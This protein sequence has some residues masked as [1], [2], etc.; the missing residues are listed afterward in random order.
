[1]PS[2]FY[3]QCDPGANISATPHLEVLLDVLPLLQ[4]LTIHGADARSSSMISSS[5]GWF[6]IHFC[7]YPPQ[8]ILMHYCPDLVETI[9]SPQ[10]ACIHSHSPFDGWSL[11]ARLPNQA[12]LQF[13][14]RDTND[15]VTAP[16]LTENAL[17]FLSRASDLHPRAAIHSVLSA[18]L[19]HQRLGHPGLTQLDAIAKHSTGVPPQL[20]SSAHPFR[21]CQTCS[22]AN[23]KRSPM[24][25][26]VSTCALLPATRFHVDFGFMRASS[27]QYRPIK[28]APR[29]VTSI[30]GFNAYLLIADAKTRY[31]FAFPTVSKAPPDE[32]LDSFLAKHGLTEGSRFLRMDQ[33]GELWR[34][35][36]IRAVAAR[37]GY[38]IE[39]TG[40][41]SANQNG[42]VER[43]N[44]TYGVMV[45]AL[46]YSAGLHPSFWS[47]ALLHAVYLKNRLYHRS[48]HSTPIFAWTGV[49]PDLAH[50]RIFGSLI[51]ARRPGKSPAK[52]DRHTATGIFTGYGSTTRH[53]QYYDLSTKRFK[54]GNHF[55]FD[56]AHFSSSA[57]PP[58]AQLL[59]DLGLD[60][61]PLDP[62]PTVSNPCFA[63]QPPLPKLKAGAPP[64]ACYAPL[65]LLEF[66]SAPVAT[67][68]T[69][70]ADIPVSRYDALSIELCGDSFGPSFD[71]PINIQGSHPTAGLV[72]LYDLDRGRC[73]LT[74][75]QPGTPAN[76]IHTWKSRLR[77][78]YILR[79]DTHAMTSVFDISQAIQAARSSLATHITLT[80]TFDEVVNTLNHAGLPQLYFDQM[81]VIQNHLHK[82]RQP[83]VHK[84]SVS[85]A[86]NLTRRKLRQS[87]AW[88][89]WL[90]AEH[91]QLDNYHAQGMFGTPTVPPPNSAVFYW[92]WVYKIKEMENNRKKARAVCDCSTRGGAAHISGHTFAPTPD[93]VDLRLQVALAAQRGFTLYHAD[94]SNAFAE[95]PRP[96]QMYYMRVDAPFAEW[97]NTRFPTNPLLPGQ[98]IPILKN[99]QGHP[100]APRQW[101]L[102]IHP[103][104]V[105]KVALTPTTHAPYLYSGLVDAEPILFLRQVDDFSI[106]CT[107]VATY[108]R[109]CDLL[110]EE[111][112]VPITRHGLLHHFNGIDVVQARTHIT[113]SVERYL[114]TVLESHGWDN[115]LP[116]SL[117]MRPDND[118]VKALDTAVPLEPDVRT[119]TDQLR[120]R[121]RGAIGELI[122]PMITTRPE[123]AFPVVKLSQFSVALLCYIMM[124]SSLF[125]A[126]AASPNTMALPTLAC[127]LSRH[128]PTLC[129]RTAVLF[130]L[131]LLTLITGPISMTYSLAMLTLTGPWTSVIAVLSRA[132]S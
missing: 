76:R 84:A 42:K 35:A 60:T 20:V 102:H 125:F 22:D 44:G 64:M 103:I 61:V 48:L 75:M 73:R 77:G 53:I 15:T 56:E 7:D 49:L 37:H 127:F 88:P 97:W 74:A 28:D 98:V 118:F 126:I 101:S 29:V 12:F 10:H 86:P 27:S 57:R 32:L 1:M 121:Y 91:V 4:P 54:T 65:P 82:L 90:A 117:P 43:L 67:A 119:Q 11:I 93:M 16:L 13:H 46:L 68:A 38:D 112:A 41:D 83:K 123:L 58:G 6:L 59:F 18:E 99:L 113:I 72:L 26:T 63:P 85:N 96:E 19:W 132:S 34:S 14:V 111:L 100:K 115:L 79:I 116:L 106:A 30:D 5:A 33:G 40:S 52:L 107:H 129:H 9:V 51:T 124:L 130:P 45:R 66:A 70:V 87:D 69:L 24:G 131:M 21:H 78:A 105:K 95:A 23:P 92:V 104:L 120:F 80:L 81:R 122:W 110:D 2:T 108:D 109:V 55:V 128:Y 25:P 31:T 17:Y 8:R 36:L 94:V 89:D 71:E 50:L 3:A 47:V 39:P 62:P 114:D